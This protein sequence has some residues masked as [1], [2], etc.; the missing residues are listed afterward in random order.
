MVVVVVV[1][2]VVVYCGSLFQLSSAFTCKSSSLF[3]CRQNAGVERCYR[4]FINGNIKSGFNVNQNRGKVGLFQGLG[5]VVVVV[6][7]INVFVLA[8]G[9]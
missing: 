4:R 5:C 9:G 3:I 2:V 1:V 7:F 8:K 6:N